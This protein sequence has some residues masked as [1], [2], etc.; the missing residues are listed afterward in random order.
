MRAC[1]RCVCVRVY[2]SSEPCLDSRRSLIC[3]AS[4]SATDDAL[5]MITVWHRTAPT[6]S[7]TPH[8]PNPSPNSWIPPKFPIC[9]SHLPGPSAPPPPGKTTSLLG[10]QQKSTPPSRH[11]GLP[12]L[13]PEQKKYPKRPPSSVSVAIPSDAH[14]ELCW[15][16]PPSASASVIY[17]PGP[18]AEMCRKFLV[19]VGF[20]G[21]CWGFFPGGFFW[22]LFPHKNEKKSDDKIRENVRRPKI[23]N[24][25]KFVLPKTDPNIYSYSFPQKGFS[26]GVAARNAN[27]HKFLRSTLAIWVSAYLRSSSALRFPPGLV[28]FWRCHLP[29]GPK[30]L[31]L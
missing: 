13:L 31:H 8:R 30:L 10:I 1:G 27:Q 4:S 20:G 18:S 15:S 21:F 3:R 16:F 17:W 26:L 19:F 5:Q 11:L 29:C 6:P 2:E 22:A 9:R 28:I 25:R 23:K 14:C 12:F 24:P 7:L